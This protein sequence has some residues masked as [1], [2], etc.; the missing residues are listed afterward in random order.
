MGASPGLTRYAVPAQRVGHGERRSAVRHA[1]L[2]HVPAG[3]H[4]ADRL[5]GIVNL[6]NITTRRL[7]LEEI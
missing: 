3:E 1:V 4:A 5:A 2:G 6:L 7:S